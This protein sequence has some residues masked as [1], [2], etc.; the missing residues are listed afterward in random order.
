[1]RPLWTRLQSEVTETEYAEFYRHLSHTEI[2]LSRTPLSI[3]NCGTNGRFP[4]SLII[5]VRFALDARDE[6]F[7][8][9]RALVALLA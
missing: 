2:Y 7:E 9:H 6:L 3:Y 8:R 5:K 4:A 1:M